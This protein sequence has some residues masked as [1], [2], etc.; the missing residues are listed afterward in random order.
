MR[1]WM[2]R[3]ASLGVGRLRLLGR[4]F[5]GDVMLCVD[6]VATYEHMSAERWDMEA[7][8][9]TSRD[10][11]LWRIHRMSGHVL[12]VRGTSAQDISIRTGLYDW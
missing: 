8:S 6:F 12:E 5:D 11:R 4:W 9:R 2:G 10:A 3:R 7:G 1:I